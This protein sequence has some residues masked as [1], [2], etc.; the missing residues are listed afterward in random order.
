LPPFDEGQC[1]EF[2]M[3]NQTPCNAFLKRIGVVSIV[4]L[5]LAT[6]A[7]SSAQTSNLPD[8]P[9]RVLCEFALNREQS[10]WDQ[11]STFSKDVA[12]AARRGLTVDQDGSERI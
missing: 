11:S 1:R 3:R 8:L 10:A 2:Q 7:E 4:A 5:T 9:D 6:V 12:E